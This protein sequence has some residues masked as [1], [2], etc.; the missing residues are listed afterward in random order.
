MKFGRVTVV[1]ES[2]VHNPLKRWEMD[3]WILDPDPRRGCWSTERC[4]RFVYNSFHA[5]LY[6]PY[7]AVFSKMPASFL[8]DSQVPNRLAMI[9]L[10]HYEI[11]VG[12]PKQ[13]HQRQVDIYQN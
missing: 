13:L 12:Q 11:F 7:H 10:V 9:Y 3:R 8:P 1:M 6:I 4:V 5:I 2:Y